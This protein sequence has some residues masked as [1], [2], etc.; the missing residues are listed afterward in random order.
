MNLTYMW[1]VYARELMRFRKLWMDTLFTPIVSDEISKKRASIEV[2]KEIG[3]T[4]KEMENEYFAE[5]KGK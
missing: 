5:S 1:A 2:I 3:E 4:I